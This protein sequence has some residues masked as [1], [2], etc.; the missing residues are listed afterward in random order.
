MYETT[1]EALRVERE[2]YFFHFCQSHAC[3]RALFRCDQIRF[4]LKLNKTYWFFRMDFISASNLN[5]WILRISSDQTVA[6]VWNS[7]RM[8]RT[9]HF[10]S[11][12]ARFCSRK[13]DP[14]TIYTT[15]STLPRGHFGTPWEHLRCQ[16]LCKPLL[17]PLGLPRAPQC[18]W[19][20]CLASVKSKI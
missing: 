18:A 14:S 1:L 16:N 8:V 10:A 13:G 9:P 17:G 4:F 19:K 2:T 12:R 3:L 7:D 11:T 20:P 15:S 5:S 6:N